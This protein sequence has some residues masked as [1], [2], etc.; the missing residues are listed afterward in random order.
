MFF[1]KRELDFL[2]NEDILSFYRS[3]SVAQPGIRALGSG[4]R[5][6]KF[7]SCHSDHFFLNSFI[8]ISY[9]D[10]S[11]S[12]FCLEVDHK[13]DHNQGKCVSWQ[14]KSRISSSVMSS[15]TSGVVSPRL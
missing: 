15:I 11:C 10:F 12:F 3:R 9:S 8:S 6:R 1:F 14:Q 5:G 7:E 13:L 2:K 4:P